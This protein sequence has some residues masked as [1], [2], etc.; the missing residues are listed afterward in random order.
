[1]RE[2]IDPQAAIGRV[3]LIARRADAL[4]DFYHR[5]LGLRELRRTGGTVWLGV[6]GRALLVLRENAEARQAPREAGLYHLALRLPDRSTLA[7]VVR[8]LLEAG[9][10]MD[11]FADHVVSEAAYLRDPEGNGVE[12]Y[13]DRPREAWF[14]G[15]E[16]LMNTLPLDVS[17]LMAAAPAAEPRA[18]FELPPQT[19]VGH[20]HLRVT[21]LQATERFYTQGLGFQVMMRFGSQAGFVSAGGYHHHLGYNTWGG[22]FAPRAEE[23]AGGLG[24]FTIRLPDDEEIE[25]AAVRLEQTGLI[26]QCDG[27]ALAVRDPS[28]ILVVLEAEGNDRENR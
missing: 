6:A 20:V 22:P 14:R 27:R 10:A 7:A 1:M 28:G 2:G 21:D 9:V 23:S 4:A 24:Y 19:I 13:S 18:A 12:L 8:Q 3:C 5:R 11:G 15:E 16:L 26:A 17:G 25:R